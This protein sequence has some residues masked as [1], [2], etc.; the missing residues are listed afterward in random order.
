MKRNRDHIQYFETENDGSLFKI[1][2]CAVVFHLAVVGTLIALNNIDLSKPAE[3]IPVF[4]MVQVDEPVKAPAAK[5]AL[6]EPEPQ[7]LHLR[8]RPSL[9]LKRLRNRNPLQSRLL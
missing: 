9:C 6:P 3:E 7:Q 1:I 2:V 8:N 4:E 5:T